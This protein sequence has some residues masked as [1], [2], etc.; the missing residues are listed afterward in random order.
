VAGLPLDEDLAE[1]GVREVRVFDGGDADDLTV[2][3][4]DG[5]E[6]LPERDGVERALRPPVL[7]AVRVSMSWCGSLYCPPE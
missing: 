4:P 2:S 5:R 1:A 6:V 3:L 7:G